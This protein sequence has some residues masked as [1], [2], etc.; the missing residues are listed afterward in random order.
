MQEALKLTDKQE[1]GLFIKLKCP[2]LLRVYLKLHINTPISKR[3]A[4]FY[5]KQF[6]QDI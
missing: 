4:F 6:T 2:L 1:R 3:K 5:R